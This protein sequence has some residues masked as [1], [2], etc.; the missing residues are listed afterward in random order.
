MKSLKN[1]INNINEVKIK[2]GSSS[3]FYDPKNKKELINI[4][5]K[6]TK[7]QPDTSIINL[8]I[9]NVSN[10]EDMSDLFLRLP[11]DKQYNM[12]KWNVSNVKYMDNMF[13]NFENF[14]SD[15]SEWDVSNVISMSGMFL[16]CKNL[17]LTFQDGM[18]PMLKT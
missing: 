10:I 16:G 12:S 7:D 13:S 5:K 6:L 11:D 18:F 2:L 17:I 15:I 14:N 1:F 3:Y 9:I 8:N 4:I